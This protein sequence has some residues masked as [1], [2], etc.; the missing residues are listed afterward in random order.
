MRV[1]AVP[2]RDYPPAEDALALAAVVLDGIADLT[3]SVLERL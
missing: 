3:P 1:V 2:N